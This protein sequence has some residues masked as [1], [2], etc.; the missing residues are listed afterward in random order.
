MS[1]GLQLLYVVLE[2]GS[3]STLRRLTSV[4]F[5]GNEVDVYHYVIQ[6]W[7]RYGRLPSVQ[8]VEDELDLEFPAA[9]DDV[10]YYLDRVNQRR[11]YRDITGPY[12]DMR[13]ALT[14]RDRNRAAAVI[15]E[16]RHITRNSTPSED[17]RTFHELGGIVVERYTQYHHNPGLTGVPSGWATLDT[18][19]GGYQ[20][21]DVVSWVARTGV[22]KTNLLL[23]QALHAWEQGFRVLFITME[24]ALAQL[25]ARIMGMYAKINPEYIRKGMLSTDAFTR[26]NHQA[27]CLE[28][29]TR[30]VFFAG[31]FH[32]TV[33]QV[34]GV[35]DEFNPDIVF[36]D[37]VYL[38]QP[39]QKA[40]RSRQEKVTELYDE[41]KTVAITRDRPLICTTQFNR[42][43]GNRGR[44]G[45]LE[46]VGYSDAIVTHSSLV[47]SIVDGDPP[48]QKT[49][50]KLSFLKGREGEQG[51]TTIN[52]LFSPINFNEVGTGVG[53]TLS[54]AVV[55]DGWDI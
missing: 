54:P 25:G 42:Q 24:M 43:S 2:Q 41:L 19:T 20:P 53:E 47:I 14:H 5:E 34:D 9:D 45:S 40:H 51:E 28:Q 10:E 17:I 33:S 23:H 50:R 52:Y 8:T 48:Y 29:D 4:L 36:I 32:K 26:L 30:M 55:D 3:L 12:H 35:I 39:T 11:W 22:G 44:L 21:G 15:E 49:R 6:H 31:N 1:D 13:D 38:V 18:Q 27:A 16:M 7:R 46:T 37:G